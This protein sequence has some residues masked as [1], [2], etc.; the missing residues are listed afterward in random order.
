MLNRP[1]QLKPVFVAVNTFPWLFLLL[2]LWQIST[3]IYFQA[4]RNVFFH[5]PTLSF[6]SSNMLETLI[7]QSCDLGANVR[8]RALLRKWCAGMKGCT[9]TPPLHHQTLSIKSLIRCSLFPNLYCTYLSASELPRSGWSNLLIS[10]SHFWELMED[11]V[12][13]LSFEEDEKRNMSQLSNLIS[14]KIHEQIIKHFKTTRRQQGDVHQSTLIYHKW[15]MLNKS[16]S[17]LRQVKRP[18]EKGR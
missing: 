14:Q 2:A 1:W 11:K 6:E 13:I 10:S 18:W 7:L 17:S 12:G 15:S 9:M 16:S 8:E 4:L 5:P 3:Y